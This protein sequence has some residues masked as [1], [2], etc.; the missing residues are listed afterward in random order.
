[1]EHL[2]RW[3]KQKGHGFRWEQGEERLVKN[4]ERGEGELICRY[5]GCGK[6]C[7][8]K[9]KLVMHEKM[10]HRENEERRRMKCERCGGNFDAEGQ[11]VS[12]VRSCTGGAYGEKEDRKQCG[13][14]KRWVSQANYARHVRTGGRVDEGGAIG[15]RDVGVGNRRGGQVRMVTCDGYGRATWP[16]ST[17]PITRHLAVGWLAG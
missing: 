9:G 15:G 13:G 3:N 12:H 6:I 7:T 1:M 14:C 10:K 4:V 11:R 5:A 16:G 2:D 8:N 17:S